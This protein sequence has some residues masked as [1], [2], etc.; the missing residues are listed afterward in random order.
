VTPSTAELLADMEKLRQQGTL[1]KSEV[2]STK[3]NLKSS[4]STGNIA[5]KRV[6]FLDEKDGEN[7]F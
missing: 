4:S 5:K 2:V 7:F 1:L 6:V 3:S